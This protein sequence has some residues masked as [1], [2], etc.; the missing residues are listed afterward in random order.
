MESL[1][2]DLSEI[3]KAKRIKKNGSYTCVAI[4]H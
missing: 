2:P 1:G 4:W 3:T